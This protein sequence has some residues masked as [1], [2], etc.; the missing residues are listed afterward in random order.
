MP[1]ESALEFFDQY[2]VAEARL[3][4]LQA[5][6]E[7]T[8]VAWEAEACS[9][10]SPGPVQDKEWLI[11]A[12]DQP[13]HYRDGKILPAAFTDVAVRGL[14]CNRLNY[15]SIEAALTRSS[16]R[17]AQANAQ[18]GI[19]GAERQTVAYATFSVAYLR[20]LMYGDPPRR[21]LAVYDT[22]LEDDQSHADVC[23]LVSGKQ[24]ER[25]LR[26]SLFAATEKTLALIL[27][28]KLA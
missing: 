2:P 27:P 15:I 19:N 4:K 13:I 21:G 25:S 14:S 16:K 26:S 28:G 10:H 8:Q 12:F 3:T 23:L 1:S 22:G 5:K 18:R 9:C 17:V 7:A 6:P 11:R 24:A 20:S